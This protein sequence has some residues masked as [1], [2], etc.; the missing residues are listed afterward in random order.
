MS[1]TVNNLAESI[2]FYTEV[3]GFVIY[4]EFERKD[5]DA[6]AAFLEL[7]NFYIELWEFQN[8]KEVRH[9]LD[10]IKVKDIRHIA[11]KVENLESTTS[12]L[13]Q[14]G[15]KFSEPKLGASGHMYSFSA[16]PNGVALEFYEA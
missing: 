15:L 11:F 7:D 2:V 13:K 10:D 14:K 3:L 9:R 12:K 6:R 1:I 4:K 8:A 5:M 16:D